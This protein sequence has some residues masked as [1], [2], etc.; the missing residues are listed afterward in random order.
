MSDAPTTEISSDDKNLAMLAHLLSILLG[1]L[2]P[3]IIW[4]MNKEKPEKEFVS[5]QA[6]E[7][8]NFQITVLLAS[9]VCGLL[10]V[11]IIGLILLPVLL[12]ANLVF[13]IIGGIAASKGNQYRYPVA[14][15]LLK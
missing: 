15:R 11:V 10:S 5:D 4:L 1:F 8:L 7:S 14:L 13:C 9:V 2:A 3:L 6:K 12:V